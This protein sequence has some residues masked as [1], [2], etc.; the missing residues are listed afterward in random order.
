[1]KQIPDIRLN[2]FHQMAYMDLTIVIRQGG[3]DKKATLGAAHVKR[4]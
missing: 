3:S 4:T 2:I 1:M